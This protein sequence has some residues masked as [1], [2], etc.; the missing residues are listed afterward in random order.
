MSLPVEWTSMAAEDPF[1]KIADGRVFFRT[2][3]LLSLCKLISS[4]KERKQWPDE[5]KELK[6]PKQ[7]KQRKGQKKGGK[8]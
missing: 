7:N 8:S 6:N 1:V 5:Q 2:E 4:I 3:D